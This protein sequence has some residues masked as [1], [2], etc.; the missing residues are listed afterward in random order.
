MALVHAVR[1]HMAYNG[2]QRNAVALLKDAANATIDKLIF[3]W[4]ELQ[5][6]SRQKPL[7]DDYNPFQMT[8]R[9]CAAC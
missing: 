7:S 8:E 4:R 9:R 1:P 3:V 2:W 6:S 5:T